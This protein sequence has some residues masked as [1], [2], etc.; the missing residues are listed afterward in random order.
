MIHYVHYAYIRHTENISKIHI[1][2]DKQLISTVCLCQQNPVPGEYSVA[3]ICRTAFFQI[4]YVY[5][6]LFRSIN[7]IKNK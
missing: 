4:V 1:S 3:E 2:D 5:D 7:K 6:L